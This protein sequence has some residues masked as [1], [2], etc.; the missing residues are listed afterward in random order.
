MIE[1]IQNGSVTS[2]KGFLAGGTYAGIKTAGDDALDLGILV[3]ESDAAVAGTYSTN[4]VLS[5]S[6]TLTKSR[7]LAGDR[8]RRRGQQRLRELL[9]R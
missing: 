3:S 1:L 7:A 9:R 6:V 4:K 2:A 5:P 8:A